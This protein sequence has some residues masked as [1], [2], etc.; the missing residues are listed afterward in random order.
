[1]NERASIP[2]PGMA[3]L[4]AETR[5]AHARIEAMPFFQALA[6]GNPG[7][8]GYVSWLRALGVLHEAVRH[9]LA[10]SRAPVLQPFRESLPDRLALLDRDLVHFHGQ[11]LAESEPAILRAHVLA[12]AI[13]LQG[14][15]TPDVLLGFLY[16][17]EGSALG[18]VVLRDRVAPRLQDCRTSPKCCTGRNPRKNI[19]P[20][21]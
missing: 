3:R 16:V 10:R 20:R 13:R 9:V 8:A 6:D 2:H 5:D 21:S 1:M 7:L 14:M 15:E 4:H 12:Q 19:A 18:G 11:G 17:L